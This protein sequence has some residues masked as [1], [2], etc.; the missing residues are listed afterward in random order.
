MSL[1]NSAKNA[2]SL[3]LNDTVFLTFFGSLIILNWKPLFYLF[4]SSNNPGERIHYI[5]NS[6]VNDTLGNLY[7]AIGITLIYGFC[8]PILLI[9]F[10]YVKSIYLQREEVNNE[11][12]Y[13]K[14]INS[15]TA[16]FQ[17][18]LASK[19][20][21]KIEEYKEIIKIKEER[22][23][24]LESSIKKSNQDNQKKVRDYENTLNQVKESN[25]VYSEKIN[26]LERENNKLKQEVLNVESYVSKYSGILQKI[27]YLISFDYQGNIN[28][29][30]N[31]YFNSI[32]NN[33]FN[34]EYYNRILKSE[35]FEIIF[36]DYAEH[37]TDSIHK[38][39]FENIVPTYRQKLESEL[40]IN[41]ENF[42]SSNFSNI[43]FLFR[44]KWLKE[45][46]DTIERELVELDKPI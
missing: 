12:I 43:L 20:A 18:E 28:F 35:E 27:S 11:K 38:F 31:H 44:L 21:N 17:S 37:N 40:N 29:I 13:K 26:E 33:E 24:E 9:G 5:E 25:S 30:F 7:T 22:I 3:K 6:I 16:I 4:F 1:L 41:N 15:N 34:K 42:E 39:N 2:I 19:G 8:Y 23:S 10:N 14:K 45:R 46:F 36:K 32:L